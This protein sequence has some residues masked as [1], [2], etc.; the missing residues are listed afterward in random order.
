MAQ[1]AEEVSRRASRASQRQRAPRASLLW[2]VRGQGNR[3]GTGIRREGVRL[4]RHA[5]GS[6]DAALGAGSQGGER[7]DHDQRLR[8]WGKPEGPAALLVWLSA[9]AKYRCDS[10][11]LVNEPLL[12][13]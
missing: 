6:R 9:N 11:R 10:S 13:S 2:R 12:M 7:Q 3:Q 8:A 5:C 1:D 4:A